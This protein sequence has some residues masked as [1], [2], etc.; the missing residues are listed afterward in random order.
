MSMLPRPGKSTKDSRASKQKN[1]E[2]KRSEAKRTEAKRTETKRTETKR[3]EAKRT[4]AKRAK[5]SATPKRHESVNNIIAK[6]P[7]KRGA[8]RRKEEKVRVASTT[9]SRSFSWMKAWRFHLM[10]LSIFVLALG[11]FARIAWLQVVPDVEQ[12]YVFL[13]D[14][15]EART[16]RSQEIPAYR[17]SIT[18]RQGNPLAISTPLV[19]LWLNPL[20]VD[21]TELPAI[22]SALDVDSSHLADRFKNYR[23][24][25]FMYLQRGMAPAQAE[26]VLELGFRGVYSETEFRRFYPEAE[27][28]AQL[29]GLTNIDDQG[30]EGI[31]LSYNSVLEGKSGA[32]QVVKNLYGQVV[33]RLGVV[34]EVEPGQDIQLTVDLRL[35]YL[36]YK[37]LK[38]AVAK[39]K[40]ASASMVIMDPDNGEILAMVSQPSFNPNARDQIN[41]G[42]MRNRAVVDSFEPGSTVKP[43]TLMAAMEENL[44]TPETEID[45][46]PGYIRV[47][48]NLIED[49][50]NYGVLDVRTI[51]AKSRFGHA[52]G[53]R[54][55][56]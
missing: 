54:V 39:H 52:S 30:I 23:Q 22:A 8:A 38:E 26:K 50:R 55:S 20:Q 56:W 28:T 10:R 45:T 51:L 53:V 18:D 40:A 48:G 44:V 35:Q 25:S 33:D 21:E 6:K 37:A 43:F 49:P 13:Q 4:E 14:Q 31:E 24:K 1:P 47:N 16:I 2:F 27:V 17:G 3:T 42:S 41:P 34:S 29:I 15:G 12:G 32:E 19:A 36:A 11:L 46:S 9:D 5:K 7:Q